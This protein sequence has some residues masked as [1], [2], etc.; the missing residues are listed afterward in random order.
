MTSNRL[1]TIQ[2]RIWIHKTN[3][4]CPL[5]AFFGNLEVMITTD[6]G[7]HLNPKVNSEGVLLV[8][9]ELWLVVAI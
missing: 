6:F 2:V 7:F 1:G 3:P 4:F 9:G 8:F 5:H